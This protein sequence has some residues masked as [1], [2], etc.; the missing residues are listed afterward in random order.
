MRKTDGGVMV[1]DYHVGER[2]R[3]Q[4]DELNAEV[5]VDRVISVPDAKPLD[6][7][8]PDVYEGVEGELFNLIACTPIYDIKAPGNQR[9]GYAPRATFLISSANTTAPG[10]SDDVTT[11]GGV[12]IGDSQ[13]ES[14]PWAINYLAD[15]VLENKRPLKWITRAKE[16]IKEIADEI[17]QRQVGPAGMGSYLTT[18]TTVLNYGAVDFYYGSALETAGYTSVNGYAFELRHT[19]LALNALVKAWRVLGTR[20]YLLAARR[21]ATFLRRMQCCGKLTT[22]FLCESQS[23]SRWRDG[24]FI[25]RIEM[26]YTAG[27]PTK[28]S[29]TATS[30]LRDFIALEGLQALKTYDADSTYGDA[31]AVGD[32]AQRT[33]ATLSTMITEAVAFLK[34]GAP[35]SDGTTVIGFGTTDPRLSYSIKVSTQANTVKNAWNSGSNAERSIYGDDWAMCL[36]GLHA[37]EGYSTYVQGIYEYLMSFTSAT[38]NQAPATYSAEQLAKSNKGTYDPNICLAAHLLVRDDSVAVKTDY[39][40]VGDDAYPGPYYLWRCV[41]LL[42]PIQSAQRPTKFRTV[43]ELLSKKYPRKYQDRLTSSYSATATYVPSDRWDDLRITTVSGLSYQT[44]NAEVVNVLSFMGGTNNA[45]IIDV[46]GAAIVGE[47]YRYEPKKYPS[48]V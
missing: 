8:Q 29:I 40:D 21:C 39:W 27:T 14:A 44:A 35:H 5:V 4:L 36:R 37:V 32:F 9:L 19:S 30:Y 15:I 45:R 20:S 13:G 11:G 26:N 17:V 2:T 23:S 7:T 12:G 3:R 46:A 43:K 6:R 16:K 10:N 41:G 22:G 48:Q 47:I 38:Q 33:D 42:S 34:N 31:T 24:A 28:R 1:C 25:W 18:D